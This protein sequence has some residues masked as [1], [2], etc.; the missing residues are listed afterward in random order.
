[1]EQQKSTS[2]RQSSAGDNIRQIA[3]QLKQ[4]TNLQIKATSHILG[5][6][7]QISKN[8]DRLIREVV[9]MVEEDLVQQIS[10]YQTKT[11]TIDILKQQFKALGEAK[12][13]FGLK[14]NSWATLVNKLNSPLI[15]TDL[16]KNALSKRINAIE[17]EIKIVR[18]E[19]SQILFLLKQLTLDKK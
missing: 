2:Q 11:Y 9:D 4:E 5:A 12:A 18:A 19:V 7:A 13:H 6:A 16:S 8:H 3:D 10:V 15:H 14:A 1:M 17:S